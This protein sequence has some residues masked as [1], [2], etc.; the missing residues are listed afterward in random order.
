[1]KREREVVSFTKKLRFC[2]T[3]SAFRCTYILMQRLLLKKKGRFFMEKIKKVFGVYKLN[4]RQLCM[5][6]MLTALTAVLGMY[7]TIR[8]GAGIKISFKFVS[9]FMVASMFGP[10]WGG[11]ACVISDIMAFMVNPVAGFLPTITFSEFLY[12]FTDGLFYYRRKNLTCRIIICVTLEI[13][14][15]NLLLTSYF[16]IPVMGMGYK[17]LIIM[18][19]PAAVINLAVRIA[20]LIT[21]SKIRERIK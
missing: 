1:M 8:I 9:V 2:D 15:I 13:L 12:G 10:L 14:F 21:L 6:G 11:V 3:V 18:R 7:C 4:V 16:L 5:L 17:E 20:L 19:L